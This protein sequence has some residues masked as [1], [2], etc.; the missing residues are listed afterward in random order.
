MLASSVGDFD[1]AAQT[2]IK[3]VLADEADVLT[4]AVALTLTAGSVIVQADIFFATEG[5]AALA[6][7]QLSTGVLASSAALETALNTQFEADGLS[8]TASVQQISQAPQALTSNDDSTIGVGAG[9]GAV[10]VLLLVVGVVVLRRM[11]S[12]APAKS[13]PTSTDFVQ[14]KAIEAIEAT[15]LPGPVPAAFCS[16]CGT[17][18]ASGGNFCPGCGKALAVR[19]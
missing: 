3:T 17:S 8:V 13:A 18:L 9:G 19:V 14:G 15:C 1:A 5:G 16:T 11:K 2:S 7:D 12:T 4:S 6:N 10:V